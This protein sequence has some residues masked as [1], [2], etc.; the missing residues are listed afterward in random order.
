V[1]HVLAAIR[2]HLVV[3]DDI[4]RC[5]TPRRPSCSQNL[6]H[7][8]SYAAIAPVGAK[9]E[10]RGSRVEETVE[11]PYLTNVTGEHARAITDVVEEGCRRRQARRQS[12]GPPPATRRPSTKCRGGSRAR[13]TATPSD[14]S[15]PLAVASSP[16]V[17]RFPGAGATPN[18]RGLGSVAT[19]RRSTTPTGRGPVIWD[20]VVEL[21]F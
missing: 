2:A 3:S 5:V 6:T 17:D 18:R 21:R 16:G 15:I 8:R 14:R 20:S 12:D 7:T 13:A 1:R 19:A 11:D 10:G 4:G 9:V